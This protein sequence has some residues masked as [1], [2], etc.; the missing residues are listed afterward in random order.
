MDERRKIKYNLE[1]SKEGTQAL[2]GIAILLV[3]FGH[4]GFLD[5]PGA[6]GVHIFL[7]LSGYGIYCS[8]NKN[9]LYQYWKK[10][11]VSVYIPY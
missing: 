3:I 9:G 2:K 5:I 1:I 4:M 11:I 6:G 8:V 10:R 7:I